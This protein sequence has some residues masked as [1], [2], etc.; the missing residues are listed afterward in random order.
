MPKFLQPSLS[1]GE[2]S[3]GMRGRVD[4]ARFAIS[5]GKSRNFITKPTGGGA[6]RNGTLFR[7]RV[8]F[9][10]KRTRIIPFIYS[11]SVKYL[12]EMGDMYLRFWVN[13]SLLTNAQK[14]VQGIS[15]ASTAV[16]T[17]NAHGYANGDSVVISGVRGMTKVNSRTFTVAAVTANTFQ[18]AGFDSSGLAAYAG[19]GSADRIVEVATPYDEAKLSSVRFTQSADVLYIVHGQVPQKELRRLAVNQ[20]ELRDFAFKRGPFR[21]FNSDE[22][23]I[24]AV[25]GTTG[26]VTVSTN[27]DT[28]TADMVGSLLYVEEKE[29]RG[30][31]P[32]ASAEKDVPVGA[33]RRSDSK[34]YRCVSVPSNK[35]SK[36]TPYYVSG[37]VRPIHDSG[38]AFDG[39]Q[40]VKDDG[41]NTYAVG[42]EWEFLHNTFGILQIQ[43]YTD[44]RHVQA[45]VIERIPDSIVGTAPI[46]ANTWTLSGDGV[47]K[48]FSI[49]GATSGSVL[50]YRV[51]IN[52]L[53]IQSNP[54]YPGGGGVNGGGSGS[55]RPTSANTRNP[56]QEI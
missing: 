37:N 17:A 29:L 19:G 39:P 22:A 20:F 46:P 36:G 28:F 25:S 13:G 24:M 8:K 44:A 43:A 21:P 48:T 11:T 3:P 35:G 14:A 26:I 27:V 30:V 47:T 18:L 10:N 4:L 41:V 42:V 55:P 51:S 34:V 23:L 31:K 16:V 33:L 53:P 1:G 50:D 12:I 32:W 2:L 40:D 38:R 7:G 49:P 15:Q 45:V 9:S 5:L 56:Q 54:Y 6:K 52:G